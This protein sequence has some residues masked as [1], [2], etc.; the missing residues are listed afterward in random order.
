MLLSNDTVDGF[1]VVVADPFCQDA[2]FKSAITTSLSSC[3]AKRSTRHKSRGNVPRTARNT[4]LNTTQIP[5]H[6]LMTRKNLH[7]LSNEAITLNYPP[8]HMPLFFECAVSHFLTSARK[9]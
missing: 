1:N 4:Q 3:A 5:H 7:S 9:H 2:P 6:S 8:D